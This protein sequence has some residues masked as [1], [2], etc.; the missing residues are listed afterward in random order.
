MERSEQEDE[1]ESD[2]RNNGN[3]RVGFIAGMA[4]GKEDT[5]LFLW[6]VSQIRQETFAATVDGCW[7]KWD[8]TRANQ[9]LDARNAPIEE[10]RHSDWE[11]S[12]EHLL[13]RYPDLDIGYARQ[14][15]E[16]DMER[17]LLFLP[18]GGRHQLIDGWHRLYKAVTSGIETLPVRVLTEA[19]AEQVLLERKLAKPQYR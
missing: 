17:P 1:K 6:V 9:F 3:N 10:F 7:Y 12:P 5:A 19:E 18:F 8:V 2:A 16:E 13:E 15:T 14:L 11:I 4:P